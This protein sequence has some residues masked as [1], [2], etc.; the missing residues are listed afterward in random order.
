MNANLKPELA[1]ENNHTPELQSA[2]PETGAPPSPE[3]QRGPENAPAEIGHQDTAAPEKAPSTIE[4]FLPM[5]RRSK[6]PVLPQVRDQATQRLEKILEEGLNESFQR[7]SPIAQQEFKIKGEETAVKIRDLL[8]SG[9]SKAK[10]I[11]KLILE[12]L[13]LLPGINRFFLEQEAKIK[14]DRIL[15][16][17][18]QLKEQGKL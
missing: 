11:F 9:H 16:A 6:K 18:E 15:Q 2:R 5:L 17:K 8:K 10:K 14:T 13:R 12:W 1:P 3:T 7:L 4:R